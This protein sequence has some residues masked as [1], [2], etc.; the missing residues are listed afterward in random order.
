MKRYLLFAILLPPAVLVASASQLEARS[1]AIPDPFL[2]DTVSID[3]TGLFIPDPAILPVHFTNDEEIEALE[4]TLSHDSPWVTVDS[5]SFIG[6]RVEGLSLKGFR[7][8]INAISIYAVPTSE[9]VIPAGTGLLGRLHFSYQQSAPAHLLTID[10][11]RVIINQIEHSTF[12]TDLN[13]SVF[14]PQFKRGYLSID[15]PCCVGTTGNADFSEGETPDLSD[16]GLMIE[17]LFNPPGTISF[18]CRDEANIDNSTDRSVDLSDLGILV[19]YL[20]SPPG[21]V[22]FPDCLMY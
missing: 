15:P 14:V 17:Y 3:S 4:V 22:I 10:T 13:D 18:P 16:L 9:P 20:F 12:F 11:V 5:F 21:E 8:D 7:I 19:L 1:T 6:G 2:P